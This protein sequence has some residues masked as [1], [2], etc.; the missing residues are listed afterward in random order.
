MFTSRNIAR[1][2]WTEGEL[3]KDNFLEDVS[4]TS[5]GDDDD[6]EEEE[7]EKEVEGEKTDE[8]EVGEKEY[9][10]QEEWENEGEEEEGELE[11]LSQAVRWVLCCTTS[12]RA[13]SRKGCL[14][15]SS[16]T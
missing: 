1:P 3:V 16:P 15:P 10:E 13:S 7:E 2:D 11:D 8:E 12:C 14:T 5:D 9:E 4:N 6:N